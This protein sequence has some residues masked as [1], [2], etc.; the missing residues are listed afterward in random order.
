MFK[1]AI[2]RTP[3]KSMINGFTTAELGLPNY[4]K[5]LVQHSEYIKALNECGL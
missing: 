5:A 4:E 2:V 1:K 3:G